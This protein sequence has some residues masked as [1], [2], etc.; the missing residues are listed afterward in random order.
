MDLR[1][2]MDLLKQGQR[3]ATKMFKGVSSIQEQAKKAE[4]SWK[5]RRLMDLIR[6]NTHLTGGNE[7]EGVKLF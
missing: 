5:K 7:E 6:V 2:D 1:R 3:K 4:T